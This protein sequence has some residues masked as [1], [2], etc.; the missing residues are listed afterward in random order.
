[1][2]KVTGFPGAFDW[3]E[4]A[5]LGE[6][7]VSTNSLAAQR[8]R[9][10]SMTSSLIP[11][12]VDVW[13][14]ENLF[15]LPDWDSQRLFPSQPAQ[16]A[17][18]YT[19]R[20]HKTYLKKVSK[21]ARTKKTLL[22]V[23]I[24]DQG[25]VLGALQ[26][27]RSR[28]PNFS[29]EEI[30]LTEGLAS[31]IA[32]GL[33]ASHRVEVE[34]FRLGQ[35]NL[36]RQVSA[37]IANVLNVDELARRVTE[38]I[39]ETFNYY[40]VGIFTIRPGTKSLRFRA[41]ASAPRKGKRKITIA[42]DVDIG[43]GLIGGVAESGERIVAS[44]VRA[45][46]RFRFMDRLPETRSE[47]AIPLKIEDR[48]LG[49]LDVQ[50]NRLDA[51]H[52]NDLLL[53]EALADNIARAV[54]GARLYSDVRR[55]ADQLSLIAEVSRSV[56][57]TLDLRQLMSEAA[58]LIHD[59]FHFPFVH[60]FTVHPNRRLIEYEAG[61]GKRSRAL[62]G[63]TIPLD[64][65]QGI[66][67]WVAREGRTVLAN[68]VSKDAHY[69][70]SPLPPKNTRSELCVPLLFNEKVLG[71]LDIQSDRLNVFIEDDRIMFEAV[72]GTIAASIRNA[73]LY[74]SEHWR[75]QVA[76]S[77]REVAGLL[78]S[79]AGLDEVL[80]SIL[81]EI[82]RNLPVD[83]SAIWLLSDGDLSLSAVHGGDPQM[84]E[85]A[86]LANP[87]GS[88]ALTRAM[89]SEN[90][91]LRK[92]AD[93]IWPSGQ[94]AGFE[95]DYSSLAAPLHV[96]G[97]PVGV[98]SLAHHAR[99]RYGHEAQAMVTT[100]ASYAAVAIENA[101]LYDS[102]QEQ[103]YASAALLQ[104]AQAVVSLNE[105]EDILGIIVRVLPILVG[106]ERVAL[107][108]W[109]A[110]KELFHPVHTYG[111]DED[112][113]K[114]LA[115]D[116]LA[117]GAFPLL[118]ESRNS[119]SLLMYPLKAEDTLEKWNCLGEFR[120]REDAE[121]AQSNE[122]LLYAVPLSV[123][124][125][126]FGVLLLQEASGG[127]RFRARRLEIINGIAQQAALAI[128]NDRL[129]KEMVVR[130]R[131]ETEVQLARQIQQT[132]IPESLPQPPGWEVAARWKTAR[133]VGG[134]F[135]DVME[136]PDQKLGLFIADVA[137]KGM[138]AALFMAL[139][140]TLVRAAVIETSSPAEALQRVNELLL[141]DT[142]QGMF[143]TAVYAVLDQNSGEL[144]YVN[145]GHNPPLWLKSGGEIQRLT[146]TG[147]ALG[148]TEAR[149][150]SQQTVRVA[151]GESVLFYT[152]G[153][154][155]EFSSNGEL[156]GEMRLM[157]TVRSAA[158][159]SAGAMLDLIESSL[160][161]FVNP[162]PLSDDLTMLVIRRK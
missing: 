23:S 107:Y 129:Q 10:V 78:S 37:Q 89:L 67:P 142:K 14:H 52:P 2:P 75:R 100:F 74:R 3:R 93:P 108:L 113:R 40:Y 155:E 32:V 124:T 73:D 11:G 15:R 39:Q 51:F 19:V 98:I 8:D 77:L 152:D 125:D 133:Q 50:S 13:L 38:L 56:T 109:N 76:D 101:R 35:L 131:L 148:A 79:N 71:I 7:L 30:E 41:G 36:V 60:L 162:I 26:I 138:P 119:N 145:A 136:L 141:P 99:S 132:F 146:R 80:D 45:D 21:K 91:V 158:F 123:K 53:L 63:Y 110:E 144:T 128:Q 28:G 120:H 47:M 139:T 42:L 25:F 103:A 43:E 95:A 65:A 82:E 22:A 55:R 111:F 27:A 130:E 150:I 126:T 86:R 57:S 159:S 97:Q 114:V 143:V 83:V 85:E 61:S 6:Q 58:A 149:T 31:I 157:E 116:D 59:Q 1:M 33:Y 66:I 161:D 17:M 112:A 90:P 24:E 62:E 81:T 127:K 69:R 64:D 46:D 106:V 151:S 115:G 154:T 70:P 92:P 18:R 4:I 20:N 34:R 140:R 84:I 12:K 135:Y 153:L 160:N 9:I 49:V 105:L 87:D 117:V 16:E 134:D 88:I 156:F 121:I 118:D 54:E 147:V 29:Q 68:D 137:D 96:G 48:I 5:N 94:A 102:A 104:V 72:A 44:D 122:P